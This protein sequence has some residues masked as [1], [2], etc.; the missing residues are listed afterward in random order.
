MKNRSPTIAIIY[1]WLKEWKPFGETLYWHNK[2]RK[3]IKLIWCYASYFSSYSSSLFC[4]WQHFEHYLQI[5]KSCLFVN[6]F[7]YISLFVICMCL[8]VQYL[9]CYKSSSASACYVLEVLLRGGVFF[10]INYQERCSILYLNN[11]LSMKVE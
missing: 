8:Q 4:R 11:T 7:L 1:H 2:K 5:C 3:C 10:P 6:F 9:H